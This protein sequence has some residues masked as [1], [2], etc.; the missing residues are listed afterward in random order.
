MHTCPACNGAGVQVVRQ[1]IMPGMY[2]QSQ[3]TCSRC[4]GRGS[5]VTRAC[6]HCNGAKVLEHTQVY[7]VEV[8]QGAPEGW[9]TVLEGEADESPDWEPGDIVLRIKTRKDKGSWRRKESSLYWK[10]TIGVD[11][12]RPRSCRPG[13]IAD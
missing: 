8:P 10:E 9:E 3:V 4:G 12:V 11:E 5:I 1:Q 7:A 13:G 2:S 6:P